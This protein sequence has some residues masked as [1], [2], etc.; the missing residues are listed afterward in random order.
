MIAGERAARHYLSHEIEIR[1]D[2]SCSI[3]EADEN[4][5]S[6]VYLINDNI[7]IVLHIFQNVTIEPVAIVRRS[8]CEMARALYER[9]EHLLISPIISPSKY[10]PTKH[11]TIASPASFYIMQA[12]MPSR[13]IYGHNGNAAFN[14]ERSET[15]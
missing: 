4:D 13:Q 12:A 5:A 9:I 10:R 6:F 11:T 7:N 3:D 15:L 8:K 1:R 14:G 2:I